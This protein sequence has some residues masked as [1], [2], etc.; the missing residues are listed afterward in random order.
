MKRICELLLAVCAV[1]S[2]CGTETAGHR[3]SLGQTAE[4][5]TETGAETVTEMAPMEEKET[6]LNRTAWKSWMPGC[7]EIPGERE[8]VVKT[9]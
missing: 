8:E 2:G 7:P 9:L 3:Q 4:Q 6:K 5:M 1:V